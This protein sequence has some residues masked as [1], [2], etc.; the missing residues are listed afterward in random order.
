MNVIILQLSVLISIF[1]VYQQQVYH[2]RSL[3]KNLGIQ[4]KTLN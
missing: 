2:I 1:S 3:S 4:K